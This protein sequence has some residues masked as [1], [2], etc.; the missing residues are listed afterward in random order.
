[1]LIGQVHVCRMLYKIISKIKTSSKQGVLKKKLE[2]D[3]KKLIQCYA[4]IIIKN[5]HK[6]K[7]FASNNFL[8]LPDHHLEEYVQTNDYKK[9]VQVCKDYIKKYETS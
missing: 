7:N 2:E 3:K 1:M 4:N 8:Y 6:I 5:I 9:L